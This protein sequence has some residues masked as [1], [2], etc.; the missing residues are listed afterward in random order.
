MNDNTNNNTNI[1]N[2]NDDVNKTPW[3]DSLLVLCIRDS[4][5]IKG[6]HKTKESIRR[7]AYELSEDLVELLWNDVPIEARANL[8]S[9]TC[10]HLKALGEAPEELSST[11]MLSEA[12][13]RAIANAPS[14]IIPAVFR[15]SVYKR[16]FKSPVRFIAKHHESFTDPASS[17]ATASKYTELKDRKVL[18]L[19]HI[20]DV[21]A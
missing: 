9:T 5:T 10:G 1:E 4:L 18:V 3:V 17:Y 12:V 2:N 7:M 19:A 14:M 20:L 6:V 21:L 16:A 15:N 13:E 8:V 11:T